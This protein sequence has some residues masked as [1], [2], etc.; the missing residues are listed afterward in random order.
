MIVVDSSALVRAL[1]D[2]RELGNKA[3]GILSLHEEWVAPSHLTAEFMHALRGMVMG[4][5]VE[6]DRAEW[7]LREYLDLGIRLIV[8][9]AA[10]VDR[11]WKLRHN[12]SAYDALYVAIAEQLDY[13]LLTC[14]ARI[15][16]S[17]AA[18]CELK[19]IRPD[20]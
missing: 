20:E 3:R 19:V 2:D 8:P 1:T 18:H 16:A 17:G 10:V 15:E 14:D 12:L 13:P 11:A 4:G 7:A 6:I 9:D 5:K